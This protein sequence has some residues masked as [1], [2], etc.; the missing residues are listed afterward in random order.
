MN[1]NRLLIAL[2]SLLLLGSAVA[3]AQTENPDE[4]SSGTKAI[5]NLDQKREQMVRIADA[6]EFE[7]LFLGKMKESLAS[8]MGGTDSTFKSQFGQK[9]GERIVEVFDFDE[10]VDQ[11]VVPVLGPRFTV[12]ELSAIADFLETDLGNSIVSSAMAGE[13]PDV[14][15]MLMSGEVSEEDA[16]TM[17][18]LVVKLG[19]KK[20]ALMNG[21]LGHDFEQ[22]VR[23]YGESLAMKV[24]GGMMMDS[25]EPTDK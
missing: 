12:D 8:E 19:P 9:L 13:S 20:Q 11:V 16:Q 14:Q 6:I 5:E 2:L 21:D 3:V 15:S 7:N 17:M 25:S 23:T 10:F 24:V 4:A 22:A 18:A 1:P